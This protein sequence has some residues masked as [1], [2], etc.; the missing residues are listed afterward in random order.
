MYFENL[1]IQNFGPLS[2]IDLEFAS[3]GL[4]IIFGPNGSGK[5]QLIGAIWVALTGD[6]SQVNFYLTNDAAFP[7]EVEIAIADNNQIEIVKCIFDLVMNESKEQEVNFDRSI[8]FSPSPN[9][10]R[11]SGYGAALISKQLLSIREQPNNPVLIPIW[12]YWDDGFKPSLDLLKAFDISRIKDDTLRA[13]AKSIEERFESHGSL[14][15]KFLSYGE[16][17]LLWWLQEYLKR[18]KFPHSVPIILDTPFAR[19]DREG[20]SL[21]FQMLHLIGLKD[22]IIAVSIPDPEFFDLSQKYEIKTINEL[23]TPD[24]SDYRPSLVSS[25][26]QIKKPKEEINKPIVFTEGK[27]DWKHLKAALRRLQSKGL[28]RK[29]DIEFLE[30]EEEIPAG[31]NELKNI[32]KQYSKSPRDRKIICVFDRD[33]LTTVNA[34]TGKNQEYRAWGNEVYSFA[35]PEVEH[36]PDLDAICLEHYYR[37]S[38]IKRPDKYGRRLYLSDEFSEVSGRCNANKSLIFPFPRKLQRPQLLVIGSNVYDENDNDVAL[39]KN[40]FA[41]NVLNQVEDFDNFDVS[42]FEKIFELIEN[43]ILY[44]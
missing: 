24:F 43:I 10:I 37:D 15:V 7:S 29:L 25:A 12:E 40:Q 30:F 1:R 27:T 28:F 23:P 6:P 32:C 16:R 14:F 22:Q 19:L 42:S 44:E 35:I 4:N 5:T 11:M 20:Q 21:L 39:S 41:L 2:T 8:N 9:G 34:V 33:I 31:E 38:E 18:S 13:F 3:R 26:L 17:Y 36:R